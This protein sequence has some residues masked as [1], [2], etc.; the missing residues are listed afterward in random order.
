MNITLKELIEKLSMYE[1]EVV[2]YKSDVHGHDKYMVGRE[3]GI[4]RR[5]PRSC[6][7]TRC[8]ISF[9]LHIFDKED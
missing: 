7:Y 2:E 3:D 9:T 5:I 6:G 1:G 8:D 4:L